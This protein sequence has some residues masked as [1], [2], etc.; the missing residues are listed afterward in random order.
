M[1]P[2]RLKIK[3]TC[4]WLKAGPLSLFVKTKTGDGPM[5]SVLGLTNKTLKWFYT[6]KDEN[7]GP[8]RENV[9]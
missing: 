4:N 7:P 6:F 9:T 5:M 2:W 8:G 1:P 3:N